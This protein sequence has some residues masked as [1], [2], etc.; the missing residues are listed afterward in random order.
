QYQDF[1]TGATLRAI[2]VSTR[3]IFEREKAQDN[4][5]FRLANTLHATTHSSVVW[6]EIWFEPG[7]RVTL[8]EVAEL[9]RNLRAMRLFGEAHARLVDAGNGEADLDVQTR[10][11]FSLLFGGGAG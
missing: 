8:D 7:D 11:R 5:L 1:S 3:D 9:E 10:D 4:L 6:R 2:R